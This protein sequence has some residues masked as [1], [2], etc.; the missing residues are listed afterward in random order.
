MQK[1]LSRLLRDP[2]LIPSDKRNLLLEIAS[3]AE[4]LGMPC[5]VVGGFV[6][7]LLLRQPINDFDIVVEG[8]A[9]RLGK[10]LAEKYGGKLTP[11]RKF[12]TAVWTPPSTFDL[13]SSTLDLITARSETYSRPGA[14]PTVKPAAIEDDLRR[15]DFTVNAMAIRLDGVHFGGLFDPLNGQADLKSKSI[16]TLHP[17]SFM[18]DPTRIF[19]AIRY[20]KRY[21]FILHPSSFALVNPDSLAVLQ[22]LSGKRIRHEFDL[23]FEEE[24]SFAMLARLDELGVFRALN[25]PNFNADYARF[26]KSAPPA[27]FGVAADEVTAGYLLWVADSTLSAVESLSRR[28]NFPSALNRACESIVRL[29]RDLASF[30]NSKPSGWTFHLEQFP[31]LAVY[32][33]WLVSGEPALKEFLVKWRHVKSITTGGDLKARGLTPG[34]RYGEILTALRAAWLDG[35]IGSLDEERR[36]LNSW[37]D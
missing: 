25:L 32:V 9:L 33:L 5:Y 4:S 7:D 18:D 15:R 3:Q 36:F 8:D 6:R 26:L 20:E 19:R 2:K 30:K 29:R 24:N 14:L 27:E 10:L 23:I 22:T 21:S 28:L 12:R 31:P 16:R 34:R 17:R 1:D 13:Q 35:E 37:A 11:H